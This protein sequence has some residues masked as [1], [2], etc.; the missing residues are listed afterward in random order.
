[1]S[2]KQEA[3][4]K[5]IYEFYLDNRSEGKKYT[6]DHFRAAKIP[7]QTISDII[8]RAENDSGHERVRGS[9]RK[10][11]I[12]TKTNIKRLKTMFDH[13][14]G[15]STR[16][17]ARKFKCSQP[18]IV[19]TL[20]T[21]T[22]IKIR[23]KQKIPSRNDDQRER[24][25]K[26]C[27][28]LYRKLQGNSVILDDES[29]FTLT[30]STINGNQNFYSSEVAATSSKVK[31]RQKAKFE[32]KI[33]VWVAFSSEGMSNPYFVPSGLGINQYVYLEECIRK[34]LIPFI[35]ANHTDGKYLFWPDLA[36]S[37]YATSVIEFMEQNGIKYVKKHDNPPKRPGMPSDRKF[38][39][40]FE[41]PCLC[42]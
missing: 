38:L 11:K 19:K 16:Q 42:K 36:R 3:R 6:I 37:H 21:K 20:S 12:M 35:N 14:D 39:G 25:P 5:Q 32:K 41:R 7:R 9:G 2:S 28:R 8:K 27:D 22:S 10:A 30:H 13:R 17:A 4:R 29:Y 18:Y 24:I 15:V 26:C 34:R 23:K 33:L 40:Y 31:Y 1:M